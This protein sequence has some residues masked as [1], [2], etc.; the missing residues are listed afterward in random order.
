MVVDCNDDGTYVLQFDD[1]DREQNEPEDMIHAQTFVVSL[2]RTDLAEFVL[3]L[4]RFERHEQNVFGPGDR[5]KMLFEG[6][7]LPFE[8]TVTGMRAFHPRDYPDS[9]WQCLEVRWDSADDDSEQCSKGSHLL[10]WDN[11][12]CL[13]STNTDT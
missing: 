9:P 6:N 8:G 1:G 10:C 4:Y 11:S 5:F 3:P 7:P 12:I 2:R 13:L